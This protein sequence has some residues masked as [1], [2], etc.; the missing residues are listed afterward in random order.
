MNSVRFHP[1]KNVVV[2]ASDDGRCFCYIL[3]EIPRVNEPETRLQTAKRLFGLKA[4]LLSL[5]PMYS[6]SH[7][8]RQGSR[9][10]KVLCLSFRSVQRGWDLLRVGESS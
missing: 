5:H 8:L 2:T 6:L 10:N 9:S 4:Y 7:G 1:K 3:P